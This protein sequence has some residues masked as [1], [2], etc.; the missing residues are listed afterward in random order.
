M[1]I[2][3]ELL[4]RLLIL[5]REAYPNEVGG[6]LLGKRVINDFVIVPAKFSRNSVHV[7]WGLIPIYPEFVGTFHSHPSGVL[8]P[9]KADLEFFS[10]FGRVHLIVDGYSFRAFSPKG[11]EIK[12]EVI[13]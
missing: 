12:L 10:N 6:I 3:H 2:K 9:S 11:E 8:F 7:F 4:R 5:A 13:E 1:K